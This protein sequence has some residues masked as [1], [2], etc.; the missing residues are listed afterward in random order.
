[1]PVV[2]VI[3]PA[4]DAAATLG[5]TLRAIAGQV[6]VESFE[7]IVVDNGSLDDTAAVAERAGARV[8]RRARGGGPGTARN[9]GAAAAS[10]DL[11]AF[12]DADCEP[13][14]SWLAAGLAALASATLVQGAVI[15]DPRAELGPFDRTVIVTHAS[16]LFET[17]S[18][19]VRR[20]AFERIGGF[21][22]GLEAPGEAPF[23]EDALF[24]WAV[25]RSGATVTFCPEAVVAHAVTRRGAAAFARERTRLGLFPGLV[26]RIPEL[27]GELCFAG[28]F[29]TPRA[30]AFDVAVLATLV[31]L[32]RR[33]PVVLGLALPYVAINGR[34]A[35]AWGR[36]LAPRVALGMLVADAVGAAALVVGSLRTGTPV[37]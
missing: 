1:M 36:R 5:R 20:A 22:A 33:R 2:S 23:G 26:A 37:L 8:V 4:R 29:L 31:A 30:A 13:D 35:A 7:V 27:R 3:V 21:T 11:L 25:R 15:A 18:L 28:V 6:G 17:A 9:S 32:S 24:G 34:D 16:G 12:T 14:P 19:F 10:A